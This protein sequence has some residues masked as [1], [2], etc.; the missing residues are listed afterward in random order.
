MALVNIFM[1]MAIL[2]AGVCL[3]CTIAESFGIR[4]GKA[5]AL[6]AATSGLIFAALAFVG[7]LFI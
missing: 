6:D 4:N 5:V 2:C 7:S 1:G 3:M